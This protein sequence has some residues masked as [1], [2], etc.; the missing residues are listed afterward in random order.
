[1][2]FLIVSRV[3]AALKSEAGSHID[4]VEGTYQSSK[5]ALKWQE[6]KTGQMSKLVA[7]HELGYVKIDWEKEEAI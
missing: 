7:V 1:M 3:G 2:H 4:I 6:E 5:G